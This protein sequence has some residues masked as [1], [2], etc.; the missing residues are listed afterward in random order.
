MTL[1]SVRLVTCHGNDF[2]SESVPQ[3]Q[4]MLDEGLALYFDDKVSG[5]HWNVERQIRSNWAQQ[6]HDTRPAEN[7]Y[8]KEVLQRS[9]EALTTR[10]ESDAEL[11]SAEDADVFLRWKRFLEFYD[12]CV[13]RIRSTAQVA[14]AGVVDSHCAQQELIELLSIWCATGGGS[15]CL[16]GMLTHTKKASWTRK[17]SWNCRVP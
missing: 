7:T 15:D 11:F 10:L 5:S 4:D 16:P 12:H 6:A 9:R 14:F 13:T 1:T 3:C 17:L 8:A 2:L